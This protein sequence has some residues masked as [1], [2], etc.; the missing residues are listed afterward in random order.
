LVD[1]FLL[2]MPIEGPFFSLEIEEKT[3]AATDQRWSELTA[4]SWFTLFKFYILNFLT[5][6]SNSLLD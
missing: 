4:V 2:F 5:S 6:D 3:A 1:S